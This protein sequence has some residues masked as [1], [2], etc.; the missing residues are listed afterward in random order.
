MRV[1]SLKKTE[2]KLEIE[3]RATDNV[4]IAYRNLRVLNKAIHCNEQELEIAKE[5]N[6]R[7][8]EGRAYGNL[9]DQDS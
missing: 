3:G 2:I 9:A 1:V 7:A 8:G 5:V 4:G 6:D